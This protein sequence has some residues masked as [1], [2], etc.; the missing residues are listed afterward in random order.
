MRGTCNLFENETAFEGVIVKLKRNVFFVSKEVLW[1][2]SL[3][4]N[5]E[6][7]RTV[8]DKLCD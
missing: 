7:C 6:L 5:V 3:C 2:K 1:T 8:N 4:Y